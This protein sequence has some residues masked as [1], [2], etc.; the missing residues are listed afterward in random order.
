M[1]SVLSDEQTW[2]DPEVFR[3]ERFLDDSGKCVRPAEFVPFS[4]GRRMCLGEPLARAE[5]FLF[6]S[7]MIQQFNFLPPE[8]GSLPSLQ[9]ILGSTLSTQPFQ[10]RAVPRK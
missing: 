2:E 10:V 1:E 8:D 9:G 3:P 5:L 4:L 7:A 6:I